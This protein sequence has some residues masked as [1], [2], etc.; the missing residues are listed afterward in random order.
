MRHITQIGFAGVV[1]ERGEGVLDVTAAIVD[2]A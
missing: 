2:D 1:H